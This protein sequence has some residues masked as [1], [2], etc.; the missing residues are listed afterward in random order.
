MDSDDISF[1]TRLAT[2]LEFMESHP[3]IMVVGSSSINIDDDGKTIGTF[4]YSL[5]P[6]MIRWDMIFFNPVIHPSAMM[7]REVFDDL[8]L[9]FREMHGAEDYDLMSRLAVQGYSICNLSE[10]LIYYRIHSGSISLNS[11]INREFADTVVHFQVCEYC[12]VDFPN[13]WT[14]GFLLV[15]FI[16]DIKQAHFI[17]KTYR[18]LLDVAKP[19]GLTKAET[20]EIRHQVAFQLLMIW[21]SQNYA[22]KLLPNLFFA[23]QVY[24][25]RLIDKIR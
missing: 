21:K 1:P 8:G 10:P 11:P 25:E 6:A 17:S 5:T 24:S 7:H 2:E 22:L 23:I 13:E 15:R 16:K 4:S 19:W 3:E 20:L 14:K 12:K 9:T 18:K